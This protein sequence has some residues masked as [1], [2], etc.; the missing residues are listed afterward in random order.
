MRRWGSRVTGRGPLIDI[1][2][3]SLCR[4]GPSAGDLLKTEHGMDLRLLSITEIGNVS[5]LSFTL[6]ISVHRVRPGNMGSIRRGRSK[7]ALCHLVD[8]IDAMIPELIGRG[9]SGVLK[10]ETTDELDEGLFKAI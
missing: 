6:V 4:I 8:R 3:V 2:L 10:G 9:K 1:A 7:E 5:E